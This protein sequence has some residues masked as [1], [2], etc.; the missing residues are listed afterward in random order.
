MK[1]TTIWLNGMLGLITG[2]SLGVPVQFMAREE[3]KNRPQGPVVGMESGG[4]YDM[5]AGTWSDD[6]SM[7]LCTMDSVLEC[8]TLDATDVMLKFVRWEIKGEYTPFGEAFD[9]GNTCERCFVRLMVVYFMLMTGNLQA[10]I[11]RS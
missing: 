7:A 1:N 2:D 11:L 5:P 6:S 9:E 4:V 10:D 3:I 8:G